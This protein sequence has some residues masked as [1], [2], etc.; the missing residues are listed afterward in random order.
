MVVRS[1]DRS[2][3]HTD[4]KSQFSSSRRFMIGDKQLTAATRNLLNIFGVSASASSVGSPSSL[5]RIH[6]GNTGIYISTVVL[7]QWREEFLDVHSP[8]YKEFSEEFCKKLLDVLVVSIPGRNPQRCRVTSFNRFRGRVISTGTTIL[9]S[10]VIVVKSEV[11]YSSEDVLDL[12]KEYVKERMEN[13]M[14][15]NDQLSFSGYFKA[16]FQ[17]DGMYVTSRKRVAAEFC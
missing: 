13:A 3:Q 11:L 2:I 1:A 16:G 15:E 9:P 12:S 8:Y 5:F 14:K 7:R 6:P 4:L 17:V 10:R